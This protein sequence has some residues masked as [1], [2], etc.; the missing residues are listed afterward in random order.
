M[1]AHA[2]TFAVSVAAVVVG[3]LVAP[4]VMALIQPKTA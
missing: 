2:I 4:K 1:K 3:L